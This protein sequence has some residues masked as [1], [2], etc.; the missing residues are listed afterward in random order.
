MTLGQRIR[1]ARK[2]AKKTME[3]VAGELGL[4]PGA[5]SQWENDLTVPTL[6][7]FIA[8]CKATGGSA[9][10]ILLARAIDPLQG[11]LRSMYEQL[12]QDGR[13]QLLGNANRILS[14]ERPGPAVHDPYPRKN[15]LDAAIKASGRKQRRA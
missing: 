7:A 10:E 3:Q 15:H 14:A 5:L 13:D 8:F 4:T 1:R 11:Q 12:S 9:D 6:D 2:T